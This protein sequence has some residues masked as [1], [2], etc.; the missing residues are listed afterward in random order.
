LSSEKETLKERSSEAGQERKNYLLARG[1]TTTTGVGRAGTE[2]RGASVR[3]S[4]EEEARRNWELRKEREEEE[5]E[6][7]MAR[8]MAARVPSASASD[9][10]SEIKDQRSEQELPTTGFFVGDFL[11]LYVLFR[12]MIRWIRTFLLVYSVYI[13]VASCHK[14]IEFARMD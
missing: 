13:F 9:S 6:V 4:G 12:Y 14:W 5:M 7:D 1:R 11:S 8:D 10:A 2:A 3:R